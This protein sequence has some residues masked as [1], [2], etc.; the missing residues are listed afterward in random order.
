M[1]INI[2]YEMMIEEG[3]GTKNP[4]LKFYIRQVCTLISYIKH[5]TYWT[6]TEVEA[7]VKTNET[8]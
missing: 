3:E 5:Y 7:P 8:F 1:Y 4:I 2:T 6:Y